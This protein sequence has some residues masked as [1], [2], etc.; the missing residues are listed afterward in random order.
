MVVR[1]NKG[2]IYIITADGLWISRI[3]N[4]MYKVITVCRYM[5]WNSLN[6]SVSFGGDPNMAIAP[7]HHIIHATEMIL[8][9]GVYLLDV[10]ISIQHVQVFTACA[11]P[12]VAIGQLK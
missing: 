10:C 2:G 4:I 7:V 5:V 8:G 6:Q 11:H 1:I 9:I 12:Y 3:V